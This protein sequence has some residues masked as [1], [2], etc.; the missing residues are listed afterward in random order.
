MPDLEVGN[1]AVATQGNPATESGVVAN[2]PSNGNGEARQGATGTETFIPEGIDLNTLPPTVR[3]YV[4]KI[5]KDM[6][7]GFTEKTSKLSETIKS[8]S[9]KAA[10]AYRQKAEQYD[11]IAT[12]E[13]F[14]KQW[15]EY[16]KT[17]SQPQAA[18]GSV[19]PK[20]A[21]LEAKFQEIN[22]KIVMTEMAQIT[23]SF[24]NAV[25][26]KGEK[27]HPEF[28]ELA[29]IQLGQL[30]EN[31]KTEE[32]SLLRACIEL[33]S[34]ATPQ[35]RLANG[36]K[37]AKAARDAIF[38]SGKKAGM[39]RLAT[40]AQNGTIPPSSTSNDVFTVTD[41]KPKNA[42]EALDM[43]KRGQMVSRE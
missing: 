33:A 35:E 43:A 12:Q 24:A 31:S 29:G 21:Q 18:D 26:E 36:F 19:D 5:N 22:D 23:D 34:G 16:V 1:S 14:V 17:Q 7:R 39:G 10:E 6:V 27:L 20:V 13:A 28:D 9:A 40:K 15:N 42:R 30:S 37:S 2:E 3:A 8:E 25:N 11:Q 32:F 4:D 38:E 41:K